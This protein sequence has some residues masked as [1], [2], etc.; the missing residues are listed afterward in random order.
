MS[1][2]LLKQP[3]SFKL[4][5]EFTIVDYSFS[6]QELHIIMKKT[7]YNNLSKVQQL[8]ILQEKLLQTNSIFS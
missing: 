6:L 5:N 1:L 8:L 4:R 3:T 7:N 2:F